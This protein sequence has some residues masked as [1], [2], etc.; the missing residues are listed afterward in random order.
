MQHWC[1]KHSEPKAMQE[2]GVFTPETCDTCRVKYIS[3]P[4]DLLA[5]PSANRTLHLLGS[6]RMCCVLT[7]RRCFP[8]WIIAPVLCKGKVV[9]WAVPSRSESQPGE[10]QAGRCAAFALPKETWLSASPCAASSSHRTATTSVTAR[11][12][13]ALGAG[14]RKD[15]FPNHTWGQ[16]KAHPALVQQHRGQPSLCTATASSVWGWLLHNRW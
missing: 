16:G 14:L 11:D 10:K 5:T 9:R 6:H 15:S 7:H 8:L 4:K 3:Q 1:P 2:L 13:G 12:E